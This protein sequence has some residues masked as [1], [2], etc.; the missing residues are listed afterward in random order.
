MVFS[1]RTGSARRTRSA[2]PSSS[3]DK[4]VEAA[5]RKDRNLARAFEFFAIERLPEARREWDF[6]LQDQSAQQRRQAIVLAA[7]A[8][9]IDRAAYAF[10]RG[11]DLRLYTLRF[12]LAHRD[13]IVRDARAADVDP[14][15]AYA[16][17]RAESAWTADARS[18]ANAYGLMQLLPATA[19]RLAREQ[20][21]E[22]GGAA[23]LFDA[24]LNIQ[25]GTLYLG[26]MAARYDGS[27]WLASAAYNAGPEPVTRWVDARDSLDPDFF[28]ETIPYQETREYV[29]RVL[30]FS[31]IYDW[32][33]HGAV[34]TLSSR[35]PRIGQAYDPPGDTVM[36]RAVACPAAPAKIATK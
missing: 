11:D 31:V 16:I 23:D 1:P 18:A 30:A 6:A 34:Q 13:E 29:S 15:W 33:L 27:P 21:L 22:Y 36:R 4:T 26:Q 19:A 5:L 9:W 32:R 2:R 12:P 28:I 25:L 20:Q 14:A 35:L 17:I 24:E 7:R 8:G 10:N 3:E